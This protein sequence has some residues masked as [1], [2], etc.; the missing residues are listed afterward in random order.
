MAF[1]AC[2]QNE[3]ESVGGHEAVRRGAEISAGDAS[4]VAEVLQWSRKC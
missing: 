3:A 1:V 2:L 4:Q